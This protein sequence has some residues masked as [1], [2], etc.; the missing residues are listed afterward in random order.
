MSDDIYNKLLRGEKVAQLS[1]RCMKRIQVSQTDPG[2][3]QHEVRPKGEPVRFLDLPRKSRRTIAFYHEEI[4]SWCQGRESLA[5]T[6]FIS[7]HLRTNFSIIV[8]SD[9]AVLRTAWKE[10]VPEYRKQ[11]NEQCRSNK[12]KSCSNNDKQVSAEPPV[13]SSTDGASAVPALLNFLKHKEDLESKERSEK[14]KRHHEERLQKNKYHHQERMAVHRK[15][16]AAS[17]YFH[18]ERQTLLDRIPS[19]PTAI[20]VR[21][22]VTEKKKQPRSKTHSR[23]ASVSPVSDD[24]TSVSSSE[25]V[26]IAPKKLSQKLRSAVKT[27]ARKTKSNGGKKATLTPVTTDTTWRGRTRSTK[28]SSL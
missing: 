7:G 9:K 23:R 19:T 17:K 22:A 14:D 6:D 1:E 4:R 21:N 10:V 18:V 15:E 2:M 16:E 25:K 11:R 20:K 12:T 24:E 8:E 27:P 3:L 13:A 26:D 5:L 28:K